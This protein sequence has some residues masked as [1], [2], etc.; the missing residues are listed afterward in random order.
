[1]NTSTET[2]MYYIIATGILSIVYGFITGRN[3]LNSSSGNAKML[4]I[5][6]AI[7]EGARA[8]LNRQYMTIAIVGIVIFALIWIVFD[9]ASGI[10]F[11]IGAF[12]LVLQVMLV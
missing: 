1:M 7:Q 2:I 11:L 12:F 5:A 3:I 6:S 10:G 9:L 4:E 8:Y